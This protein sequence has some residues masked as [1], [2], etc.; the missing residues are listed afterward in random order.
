MCHGQTYS[1]E[2][3]PQSKFPPQQANPL[4]LR[5]L[6]STIGDIPVTFFTF[7]QFALDTGPN[8]RLVSGI[9]N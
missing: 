1:P 8:E 2:E 9:V 3:A 7:F 5:L 6:P 4:Q